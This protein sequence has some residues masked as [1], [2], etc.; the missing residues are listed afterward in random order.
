MDIRCPK[1]GE[2]WELDSIHVALEERYLNKPRPW[3]V[4]NNDFQANEIFRYELKSDQTIYD[5]YF[6]EVRKDFMLRGCVALGGNATWC[7]EVA[8]DFRSQGGS[9][10][11]RAIYDI[12]GD[13]IDGAAS[14]FED[15][16]M[17]GLFD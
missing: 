9:D 10:I 8:E 5:K 7:N 4:P 11:A 1:C 12:M 17:L 2:P 14:A 16:E 3:M 6:N 15:A 13:D